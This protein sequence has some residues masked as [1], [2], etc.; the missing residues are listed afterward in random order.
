MLHAQLQISLKNVAHNYRYFRSKLNDTT[1]LLILIKANSYGHGAVPF[2]QLMEDEGADYF[3]V[4]TPSEGVQLRQGGISLPILVLTTGLE[5]YSLIMKNSL[6]PGIPNIIALEKL[7]EV[8]REEGIKSYPVHIKLDTGMHRLGF[9]EHELAELKE[10]LQSHPQIIVKSI[11]SHLAASDEPEHDEFTLGQIDAYERMSNDLISILPNKPIRHILNSAGIERFTQYQMDMC[12]LG[13]GIYGIS[14]VEGTGLK[15][16]AYFRCPILQLKQLVKSDGTVGYGRRGKLYKTPHTIA[17]I[18]VGYADGIHRRLGK[19]KAKFEVNGKMVA[20]I[21]NVCMDMCM[22]D[23]TGV[24]V[25]VGDVVTI[26]GDKPHANDL[27]KLMETI[28]YEIFTAIPARVEKV[29]ID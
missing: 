16:S 2:A 4:A 5:N 25:K 10:F 12:R 8:M 14:P 9:M 17:T 18:P 29:I 23:V 13:V 15:P 24:D 22:L 27:A 1:K 7:V 20:T 11:Y 3:G 19:G 6:E 21:G 26:F 28:P